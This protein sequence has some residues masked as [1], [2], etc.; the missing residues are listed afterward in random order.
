MFNSLTSELKKTSKL[1]EDID[2]LKQL[3]EIDEKDYKFFINREERKISKKELKEYLKYNAFS[4]SNLLEDIDETT[5]ELKQKL[6]DIRCEDT[7]LEKYYDFW[8]SYVSKKQGKASKELYACLG[9]IE[10]FCK[11]QLDYIQEE[12]DYG[13]ESSYSDYSGDSTDTSDSENSDEE[14]DEEV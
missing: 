13:T 6:P 7:T 12:E 8:K 5:K 11:K 14:E 2:A 4:I 3:L 1:L 9:K 10:T